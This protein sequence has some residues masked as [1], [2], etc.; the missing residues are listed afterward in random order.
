MLEQK[1]AVVTGASRGIGRAI[2]ENWQKRAFL[3]SSITVAMKNRQNRCSKQLKNK[4]EMQESMDVMF[5]DFFC[6]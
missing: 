4:G 5:H 2:A 1:V 6:L 3:L